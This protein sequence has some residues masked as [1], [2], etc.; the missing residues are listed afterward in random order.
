MKKLLKITIAA[1]FAAHI[2][3]EIQYCT[4]QTLP[5]QLMESGCKDGMARFMLANIGTSK[6]D[7]VEAH[8]EGG[9]TATMRKPLP[10]GGVNL[11]RQN[12]GCE[13]AL[14]GLVVYYSGGLTVVYG[15]NEL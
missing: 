14:I 4:G 3:F 15:R 9:V 12:C 1:F 6:I 5:V 10:V 2:I 13:G 11:T 7:S 8:F